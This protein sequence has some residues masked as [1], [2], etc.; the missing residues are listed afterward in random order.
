MCVILHM[1]IWW[2][3]L[4]LLHPATQP[5]GEMYFSDMYCSQTVPEVLKKSEVLWG[6]VNNQSITLN[7]VRTN[8]N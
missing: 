1:R 7:I 4:P 2:T 3:P 6:K 5:G 8:S